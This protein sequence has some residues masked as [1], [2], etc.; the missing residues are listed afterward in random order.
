VTYV[1]ALVVVVLFVLPC[2]PRVFVQ[3]FKRELSYQR[4]PATVKT[5]KN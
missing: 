5:R 3:E 2:V 4:R 1:V